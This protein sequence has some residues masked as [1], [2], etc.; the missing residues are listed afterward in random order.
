MG[1]GNG[2]WYFIF[3]NLTIKIRDSHPLPNIIDILYKFGSVQ[4][5]FVFDLASGFYLIK[6]SPEDSH[7]T[8]FSTP[9]TR[10]FKKF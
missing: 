7:K 10:L 8:A 9:S 1:I 2:E 3:V 6:M 5:C 4:Y